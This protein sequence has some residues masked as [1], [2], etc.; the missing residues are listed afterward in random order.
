MEEN[1]MIAL[2]NMFV[3]VNMALQASDVKK[4]MIGV[5]LVHVFTVCALNQVEVSNASAT[6]AGLDICATPKRYHVAK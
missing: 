3:N 4:Q 6:K 2:V 1:V 5:V